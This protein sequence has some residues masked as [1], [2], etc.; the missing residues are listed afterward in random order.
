MSAAATDP[1]AQAQIDSHQTLDSVRETL[2][3]CQAILNTDHKVH[4]ARRASQDIDEQWKKFQDAFDQMNKNMISQIAQTFGNEGLISPAQAGLV[5]NDTLSAEEKKAVL[6]YDFSIDAVAKILVT[7]TKPRVVVMAGAG[8]SV[9]AGIPDFRSPDGLYARLKEYTDMPEISSPEELFSID[10]FKRNPI[11]FTL[12][13]KDMLP[14][15]FQPTMTHLFLK[16][17]DERGLLY[18]LYSQNIDT[19]E[20][21]SGIPHDKTVLAHGSFHD[22]HCINPECKKRMM[23]PEWRKSIDETTPPK[24]TDCGSLVK[25]DIVFFGESLP[26]RFAQ[27]QKADFALADIVIIL[28]TSLKV[29]PFNMLA[30]KSTPDCPR[31]L[32]NRDSVGENIGLLHNDKENNYRDIFLEGNCDDQVTALMKAMDKHDKEKRGW[33]KKLQSMHDD[34]KNKK[35]DGW[36]AVVQQQRDLVVSE[37]GP[38][39]PT[40]RKSSKDPSRRVSF[41]ANENNPSPVNTKK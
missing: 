29:A 11:P 15:N 27:L 17:L 8:I 34:I 3:K 10:Y 41:D 18:R 32:I 33:S 6:N 35:T 36:A 38:L 39:E 21:Q 5:L 2:A 19:L 9:S 28:G 20:T 25:P 30:T 26:D 14:G 13:A 4:E 24:C 37:S 1:C 16:L 22:V 40:K 23:L 31:V 7:K 12:R